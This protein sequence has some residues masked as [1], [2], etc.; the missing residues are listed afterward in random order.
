M[1]KNFSATL[2]I[3]DRYDCASIKH[4]SLMRKSSLSK[5]SSSVLA[6]LFFHILPKRI[7]ASSSVSEN[8]SSLKLILSSF[9]F[10]SSFSF[11]IFSCLACCCWMLSN[12]FGSTSCFWGFTLLI[13]FCIFFFE[14][15]KEKIDMLF[16]LLCRY[17][18]LGSIQ[19]GCSF[20]LFKQLFDAVI[21]WL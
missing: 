6:N 4:F 1:S 18:F 21:R 12:L 7:S 20:C 11:L 17:T 9:L 3:L 19:N 10:L 2:A 15:F 13:E 14:K 8:L 16:N 5:N